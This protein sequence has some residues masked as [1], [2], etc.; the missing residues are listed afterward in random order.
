M[1]QDLPEIMV[2]DSRDRPPK[3]TVGKV[4]GGWGPEIFYQTLHSVHDR[5]L[6]L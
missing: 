1:N 5:E 4:G 2:W 6:D 3:P